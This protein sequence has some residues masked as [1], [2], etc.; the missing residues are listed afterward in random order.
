MG[1]AQVG[2]RAANSATG[3][4]HSLLPTELAPFFVE[5]GSVCIDGVSLTV[6]TLDAG[7]FGVMLI[8][9][10]QQRT[11]LGRKTPG[12]RHAKTTA[13]ARQCVRPDFVFRQG[14]VA[15]FVDGCFW[16][17]CPVHATKPRGNAAFWREKL[18]RNQARD[19]LVTRM[20]RTKGWKVIR[21]WEHELAVRQR[22]KLEQKLRRGL[23][24]RSVFGQRSQSGHGR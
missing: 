15:L 2:R 12:A 4:P 10:T 20:L 23:G 5:K 9:E 3:P 6:T 18:A 14:R 24:T 19:R 22:A 7:S 8:P 17:A 16:H 21:I 1:L 11:S 13:K